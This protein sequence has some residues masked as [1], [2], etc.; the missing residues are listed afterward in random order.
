MLVY[1]IFGVLGVLSLRDSY[2]GSWPRLLVRLAVFA[3]IFSTANEALQLYTIDR[4]ASVTD[5]LSAG[6]GAC[7]GGVIAF[8]PRRPK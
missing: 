6:I 4:V 8:S 1:V 3:V 7:A 2:R 5:I